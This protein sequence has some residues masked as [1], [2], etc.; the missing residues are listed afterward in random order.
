MKF[1]YAFTERRNLRQLD[2]KKPKIEGFAKEMVEKIEKLTSCKLRPI[3]YFVL[4][5]FNSATKVHSHYPV[6]AWTAPERGVI[7]FCPEEKR[8][9]NLMKTSVKILNLPEEV[10]KDLLKHYDRWNLDLVLNDVVGH[11]ICH[12][13]EFF[14]N[15]PDGLEWFEEGLCFYLPRRILSATQ[16]ELVQG[17]YQQEM[18]LVSYSQRWVKGHLLKDFSAYRTS[19]RNNLVVFLNDYHL[20]ASAIRELVDETAAGDVT[21]VMRTAEQII[22]E[23]GGPP[24]L[25]MRTFI[26]RLFQK[27]NPDQEK[28]RSFV[29]KFRIF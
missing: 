29:R 26:Q 4:H 2:Q 22:P 10:E 16:K 6:P 12:L 18:K 8:W 3:E 27:F 9:Q 11:E 7:N 17:I 13:L 14:E 23:V 19:L 1:A 21:W 24:D 5:D 15:L 25:I 28:F 20:A